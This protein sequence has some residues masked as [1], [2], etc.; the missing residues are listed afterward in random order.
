MRRRDLTVEFWRPV[1]GAGGIYM[2]SP[3]LRIPMAK[4]SRDHEKRKE[5]T[6]RNAELQ[7]F[8]VLKKC[9]ALDRRRRELGRG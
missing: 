7:E 5:K 4:I 2:G 6:S 3:S 8:H 1:G 9:E